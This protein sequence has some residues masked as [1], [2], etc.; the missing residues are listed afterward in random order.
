MLV[1]FASEMTA[2]MKIIWPKTLMH[3][4]QLARALIDFEGAH[5]FFH[6]SRWEFSLD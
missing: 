6:V 4:H 3:S 2:V 1:I 5:F